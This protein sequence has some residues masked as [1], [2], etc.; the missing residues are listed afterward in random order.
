MQA[1]DSACGITY[2]PKVA[3]TIARGI[4]FL[5]ISLLLIWNPADAE[6]TSSAREESWLRLLNQGRQLAAQGERAKAETA[7]A[8]SLHTAQK[9]KLGAVPIAASLS[10][11]AQL[12]QSTANDLAAD[13]LLRR[14]IQVL[15][16]HFGPKHPEVAPAYLNLADFLRTRGLFGEAEPVYQ[17]WIESVT[18]SGPE[19]LVAAFRQM[20]LVYFLEGKQGQAIRFLE[21]SLSLAEKTFGRRH[22]ETAKSLNA[23]GAVHVAGGAFEKSEQLLRRALSIREEILGPEDEVVA[24]TL[25]QLSKIY[26]ERSHFAIAEEFLGRSMKIRQKHLPP[27]HPQLA[28]LFNDMGELYRVQRE[29]E[30]AEGF[31][32]RAAGIWNSGDSRDHPNKATTLYNLGLLYRKHGQARKA[33]PLFEQSIGIFEKTLGPRHPKSTAA[34]AVYAEWL[35]D[36]GRD[37]E[38]AKMQARLDN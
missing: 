18:K 1:A 3:K 37:A 24:Q 30:G 13:R 23:L 16:K 11:L 20:A 8:D 4:F 7:L 38:A 10:A 35:R 36:A 32:Q 34:V 9:L 28:V 25:A 15:E 5:F 6:R 29:F 31:F 26:R 17:R 12:Y 14:A 22:G 27:N 33:G 19:K 21:D 2:F